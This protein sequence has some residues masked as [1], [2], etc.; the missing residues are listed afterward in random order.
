L[1]NKK[2]DLAKKNTRAIFQW[3]NMDIH[4]HT[5]ASSDYQQTE[6]TY[7]DVLQR[8]ES[9]GLDIIAFTDHNTVAGYRHMEEEI[10][11]LELLER[12]NRLM[13]DEKNRL[14]EYRRLNSKILVLPGFEVT[15]T[16]GFH[17]IGIFPREKPV[18]EIEHLLLSL[19][20]PPTLLDNGSA[21]VGATSDVLTVYRTINMAGGLVIAAHANSSN[22]VA[23]KGFNFGGQTKIAYTQDSNL[24]ALEVTDLEV[25]GPR[26]TAA[27]FNGTKPEYPRRMHC[28]QGSDSHRLS[29]DV[30]RKKI[31]GIGDRSTDVFL[32]DLSF[33]ALRDLF[34]GSDFSRTRPHRH[35]EEPAFDFVLAA[36]DEGPNIVQAF[37]E[38]LTVRGGKLYNIL[39]DI[40]AFANTNGGTLYIGLSSEP[41]KP[42][43]GLQDAEQG[44]ALLEKELSARI[45]PPIQCPLDFQDV[46]GKKILRVLVPRGDD[47]PYALDDNKIYIRNEAETSLAVRDEIVGLVLRHNQTP[48]PV[49]VT[50]V[51][52]VRALPEVPINTETSED[53][54][55][56]TGVEIVRVEDRD[57]GHYYTMRDLRNGNIV[58][59]V[60][61]TSARRLWHYAIIAHSEV[62]DKLN[63]INIQW[64]GDIGLIRRRK[65]GKS[66]LFDFIQSTAQGY[67]F[68]FGVTRDGI[69]GPWKVFAGEDEG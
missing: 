51:E 69:H 28:I 30:A 63:D 47:P 8:A 46:K 45:S 7:L 13:P 24:H 18:R 23:M 20:I 16:F 43:L 59:N 35:T 53:F 56:R 42:I 1:T 58:K 6:V 36:R 11:Q 29:Q 17:I 4:I 25:K 19:N 62:A 41:R 48:K 52:E 57:N 68:F 66:D 44:L 39:S 31:L 65:Q 60:T 10:Q 64:H 14:S 40:C 15:A 22:G 27:F 32:A 61:R 50:P 21:T 5:P 26:S 67:R 37:H 2:V 9:R 12:L 34:T 49:K 33:E 54:A 3:H 55:P 38:N